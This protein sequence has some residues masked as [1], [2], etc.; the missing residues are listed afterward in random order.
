MLKK[1]CTHLLSGSRLEMMPDPMSELRYALP[2]GLVGV[3]SQLMEDYLKWGPLDFSWILFQ[4]RHP[5][6]P[7]SSSVDRL[8]HK[9]SSSWE[10]LLYENMTLLSAETPAIFSIYQAQNRVI[11]RGKN[12]SICCATMQMDYKRDPSWLN[13]ELYWQL[14]TMPNMFLR[15]LAQNLQ[16]GRPSTL[17][18]H[19]QAFIGWMY[20]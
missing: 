18:G 14:V 10:S 4:R 2:T 6:G 1:K 13:F 16:F 8:S 19:Q 15:I 12:H 9:Q 7:P 11:R 3:H 5:R 20:W 17:P